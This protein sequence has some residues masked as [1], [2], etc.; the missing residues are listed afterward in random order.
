VLCNLQDHLKIG[1][2][3]LGH[4]VLAGAKNTDSWHA[5]KVD[6]QRAIPLDVL[7][8]TSLKLSFVAND[9]KSTSVSLSPGETIHFSSP[10]F[11]ADRLGRLCLSLKERDSS[12]IF[13]GMVHNVSPSIHTA[14]EDSF[15]EDGTTPGAGGSSGS[16][17]P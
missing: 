10:E 11:T 9:S 14:L 7:M 17:G 6:L 4:P 12:A 5:R 2:R 3:N 8:I 16:P 1:M 15:N 13:I